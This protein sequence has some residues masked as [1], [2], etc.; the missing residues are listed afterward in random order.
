MFKNYLKIA[1]RNLIKNKSH[2]LINVGGLT[3]GIVCA[4]V[5][6]LIIQFDLSFDNWQT[7]SDQIYRVV[8]ED[9]EYGSISYSEGGPYPRAEAIRSD[10]IGIEYVALVNT[11]FQTPV[12]S[13]PN[14]G[15]SGLRFK[16]DDLALVDADYFNIF[17]YEWISGNSEQALTSPNTA[18]VS[19]DFAKKLFSTTDVIGKQF[20]VY[21]EDF[22]DVEI[23]GIVKNQPENS[24]FPFK[25]FIAS[26]SRSRSGYSYP[27]ENTSW[28]SSSSS[29]QNYVKL[30]TG[31]TPDQVNSQFDSMI[32]KYRDEEVAQ[33]L[34]YFLQ[35]LSE[36]HF[37][38]R[39][40]SYSGRIIE[41]KT[42]FSL[43]VIGFLLLLTACINFINLNTAIA[44]RR[45]KE[46]GLRKTL[47]GTKTQLTLH[48]LGETAFIVLISIFLGVGFTEIILRVIEPIL[49]FNLELNLITN[50]ELLFFVAS[51][52]LLL[53]FAAGWYPAQ[54]L[55]SFNPIEAIRNKINASYGHGLSL[56]RGLI[57]VQF[58][59]T[60]ILIIGTIII[61]SQI[62]F[63]QTRSLGY[64]NDA[65]I[66]VL[67]PNDEE[68]LTEIFKNQLLTSSSIK[69]V[70]FSNTGTTSHSVWGSNYFLLKDTVRIE[71]NTQ[72][73]VVD[74]DFVKTYG[75]QILAGH[76]LAP[77]D[78]I[79]EYLVNEA[80]AKQ[81]GFGDNYE[82]L[83]GTPNILWGVEAPIVGVVKDF[84]TQSLHTELSPTV[85]T[86]RRIFS[87]AAIRAVPER[88]KEAI[89]QTK[90]AFEDA[91]PDFIFEYEFLD[92]NIKE[93]YEDEQ[94]TA[95]IMNAFTLVAI[96][97]GSLGLFGLVSYMATTKTKEIGVR[98]VLGASIPDIL[99]IFGLE[100]SLLVG[101]SFVIA[102]PV[103][104]YLMQKWLADFAYRIDLGIGIFLLALGGTVLVA[105]LTVSYKTVSAAIANPV[106]SLKSE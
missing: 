92:E 22:I 48:F 75:L 86:T 91:Y 31:V 15:T 49:G 94:R 103:S 24:D 36:I 93:M 17:R 72:V 12:I 64:D 9:N 35:P 30:Q 66:E 63:F 50:S 27:D 96:L 53:T 42:L 65:L 61:A 88:T 90:A 102:A 19:E 40:G 100:L 28:S 101:I 85:I 2:T 51:L 87:I 18:I 32:A 29:H 23:T 84:N 58:A 67:I 77:S 89:A 104:W 52:F 81:V 37:D 73:K 14:E 45:S 82:A 59:I 6:F 20:V 57:I 71:N 60:Q 80:F 44:V 7:N 10:I 83:I 33:E 39:F 21:T 56:R 98:K 55:S 1:L 38:G 95:H 8:T 26:N 41:K 25:V 34:E 79:R 62:K 76:D 11:N 3:L 16:E 105:V 54:Y 97:I 69:N 78:S 74:E 46:V 70:T 68:Q 4:L 43:G 5:I 47:G 99:K 13:L 106:D